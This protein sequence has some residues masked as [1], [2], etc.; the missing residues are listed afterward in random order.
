MNRIAIL[1]LIT[2][3]ILG[4]STASF[5]AVATSASYAIDV[6]VVDAGGGTYES[7]SY[8]ILGK[9]RDRT[10]SDLSSMGPTYFRLGEGFI[11]SIYYSPMLN[12][13]LIGISPNFGYNDGPVFVTVTGANFQTTGA[14]T[15]E[16]RMGGET[17]I[18]STNVT[19]VNPSTITCRFDLTAA[20]PGQ[21]DLYLYNDGAEDTLA[22]AF[23]VRGVELKI[24]G[25][26]LNFPNPFDPDD[27]PTIIRYKLTKDA[28]I[29]ISLY[30]IAGERIWSRTFSAGTN[31][32][33]VGDN[34]VEWAGDTVYGYDVP[35]GVYVCQIADSKGNTL[36]IIKIAIIR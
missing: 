26:A 32:G 21:W 6:A 14:T 17:P 5:A 4:V 12:P 35:N 16:L 28:R 9:L 23:T 1:L 2:G 29:R 24:V 8:I 25:P 34:A 19:V 30:S 10:L 31:G 33:R 7:T 15:L 3:F 11:R 13:F 18:A 20:R 22:S 36:A 27:G